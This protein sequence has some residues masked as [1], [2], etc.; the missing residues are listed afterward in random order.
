[1]GTAQLVPQ[2]SS[3]PQSWFAFTRI[4]Y[5]AMT[6]SPAP[7]AILILAAN[8][9][10][11]AQFCLEQEVQAIDDRLSRSR[12]RQQFV[13][14]PQWTLRADDLR[15]A[16]LAVEPQIVHV[17]GQGAE[18]AGLAVENA[19]GQMQRVDAIALAGLFELF[20][21][22]VE[23][24][25]LN[26]CYAED[27]AEAI[28][29][30]VDYVIGLSG[31]IADRTAL[32]FVAGFYDAL[33]AGRSLEVAYKFGCNAIQLAGVP[34]HL[35]PVLKRRS[36][37]ELQ[38]FSVPLV[39]PPATA[40]DRQTI[41]IFFSYAHKDEA[42]RDQLAAHLSN[43]QRQN[44]IQQWHDRQI[45]PGSEWSGEIDAY[46]NKADVI[47]LLISADFL[48]SDYCWDIEVK[49]AMQRHQAGS[50]RVVPVL[51]RPVDWQ[52]TP[53]SG[54]APL[55]SDRQPVTRWGDRDEAF[56]N[57]VQGLRAVVAE[58]M[59]PS[60]PPAATGEPLPALAAPSP[61]PAHENLPRSGVVQFVG[62]TAELEL[63]H[64]Q[65][66]TDPQFQTGQPP[67]IVAIAG[68]AGVGKTEFALQYARQHCADYPGGICWVAA[69]PAPA[70]PAQVGTQILDFA[71][72]YFNL[73]PPTTLPLHQQVAF[74][75]Q[76][77]PPGETLLL[78]DNVA[79]YKQ[80][81]P[82][83]P[84][85]ASR[86][87]VLLTTRRQLG[88]AIRKLVL[89]PLSPDLAGELLQSLIG[90]QR[91]QAEAAIAAQLCEELGYLPL[92]LELVGRYLAHK[93]DMSLA[94]M[95]QRLLE[96]GLS[97]R[98]TRAA[99]ADMTS[100]LGV[101]AAFNLSWADLPEDAKHLG[102]LLSL[103][104]PAPIPWTLV[105]RCYAEQDP[106]DLE[107]LRDEYWMQLHLLQRKQE[108]VY[109][110]NLLIRRFLQEQFAG[111]AQ[112]AA[113]RQRFCQ[114]MVAIAQQIP[115]DLTRDA[116]MALRPAIPHL[117]VA[118][119]T[120]QA[121]LSDADLIKPFEGLGQFY[122]GQGF[123][124]QAEDWYQ[125]CG[126]AVTQRFGPEHPLVAISHCHLGWVYYQQ[127]RYGEAEPLFLQALAMQQRLLGE[128]HAQVA[129]SLN[130][131]ALLY[132]AAGD[133]E[134]AEPL[135]QR[136]L[137][138]R[139]QL[140]G[141]THLDVADSL[142]NLALLYQDEGRYAEA[143]P[144]YLQALALRRQ[145]MGDTYPRIASSLNNLASCYAAQ[146]RYAE[147]E[148]LYIEAR[149]LYQRLL[150]EEHPDFAISLNN[151]AQLYDLQGRY[152]EAEPLFAQALDLNQ[153]VLGLEHPNV[154]SSLNSLAAV[155]DIQGRYA[156]AEPLYLR[157]L[158]LRQ[159]LLGATHPLV[160]ISLNNLAKLYVAQQRYREAKL[161][162]P[163]AIAILTE[164][165]EAN[166]PWLAK[167]Q[168]NFKQMPKKAKTPSK[169]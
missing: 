8:P 128:A 80:V 45:V 44:V 135:Y 143:E 32:K 24:V 103:F 100:Q 42:L 57:I 153:Q 89:E 15:Q 5:S 90:R 77:W 74:C 33:G 17:C 139:Q 157:A 85:I 109:Q 88:S 55:P 36:A 46:L 19:S 107:D 165:L 52:G 136:S 97:D 47:L 161:L 58:F 56:L 63:L 87:Q 147:A 50:A 20:A 148:T 67:A 22:Q 125:R 29:Q 166:H 81:E 70:Q 73:T 140:L 93:P 3:T 149:D 65:F 99:E 26:G 10:R 83:L 35:V 138:L 6:C 40:A 160:A 119:T 69:Q 152:A 156:E 30:H 76:Q 53:F 126:I 71:R 127:G 113:L 21:E 60:P 95:Q 23:C 28:S 110:L 14:N 43:L 48:A 82:F 94:K 121:D 155:Y 37:P 163:R 92:G 167:V 102:G 145:L 16:L 132:Q 84:P 49:H 123:Y 124:D 158:E 118:A 79:D 51:L 108:G 131:L 106:D 62:R 142:N 111:A 133:Y 168:S 34:Q 101:Q 122:C 18:V 104:A 120:L 134:K 112:G 12:N 27:Q 144:L 2:D 117:A 164:R 59:Q 159:R 137:T 7:K 66:Q 150:G 141:E 91:H 129:D 68:M 64:R 1:M 86:F 54:L 13:L 4:W 105:E 115:E 130:Y 39:G 38:N 72:L 169:N 162:Y 98:A 96:K 146:Q 114:A 61:L 41:E 154:A 151:L 9:S 78:L 11:D 75:W 116:V 25:L 31:A